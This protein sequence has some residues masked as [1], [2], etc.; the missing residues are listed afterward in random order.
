M[1]MHLHISF[2]KLL[3]IK[4]SYNTFKLSNVQKGKEFTQRIIISVIE[5]QLSSIDSL[6]KN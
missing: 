4:C 5:V 2:I 6:T 3:L 1:I